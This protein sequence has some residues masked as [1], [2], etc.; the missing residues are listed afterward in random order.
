MALMELF[1]EAVGILRRGTLAALIALVPLTALA[2]GTLIGSWIVAEQ[3]V[4]HP[5]FF[6][7]PRGALAFVILNAGFA[8]ALALFRAGPLAAYG[9][10]AAGRKPALG[11]TLALAVRRAPRLLPITLL[12]G[13]LG[14]WLFAL[15]WNEIG[16]FAGRSPPRAPIALLGLATLVL[17]YMR[18]L[19][20]SSVAVV[21]EA[22]FVASFARSVRA[23]HGRFALLAVAGLLPFAAF[24]LAH[25]SEIAL[26]A[27]GRRLAHKLEL[28]AWIGAFACFF[29]ARPLLAAAAYGLARERP[30]R[31]TH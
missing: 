12:S 17:V 4:G 2:A 14:G 19:L 29:L 27:V 30:L 10:A 16:S 21:V 31:G 25:P 8:L 22:R 18:F 11:R 15:S 9:L 7:P 1:P 20:L 24:V 23:G 5:T 3:V 13:N 28:L 26:A 6:G